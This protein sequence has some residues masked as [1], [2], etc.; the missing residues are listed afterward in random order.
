MGAFP[1]E[2]IYRLILRTDENWSYSKTEPMKTFD[3]SN[4]SEKK[5]ALAFFKFKIHHFF[6]NSRSERDVLLTIPCIIGYLS[7]T[8]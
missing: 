2:K 7:S 5:P 8:F 1:T 6:N 3:S 4:Q